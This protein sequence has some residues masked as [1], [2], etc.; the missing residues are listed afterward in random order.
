MNMVKSFF[1][2]VIKVE[3]GNLVILFQNFLFY[4]I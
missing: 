3:N 2:L 1:M 4:D